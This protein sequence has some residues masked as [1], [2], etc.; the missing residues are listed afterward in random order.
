VITKFKIFESNDM[1]FLANYKKYILLVYGGGKEVSHP[2][3]YRGNLVFIVENL[4]DQ[5]KRLYSDEGE[6]KKYEQDFYFTIPIDV[7]ELVYVYDSDNFYDILYNLDLLIGA[8]K[9]NL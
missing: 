7:F 9:Y 8:K 3:I 4:G 5:L 6:F 1:S 2:F